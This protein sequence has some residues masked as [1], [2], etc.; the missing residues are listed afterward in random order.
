VVLHGRLFFDGFISGIHLSQSWKG[1]RFKRRPFFRLLSL[2]NQKLL[3][4]GML[5][6]EI[7]DKADSR[8]GFFFHRKSVLN[9]HFVRKVVEKQPVIQC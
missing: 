7:T 4:Q 6:L 3:L 1:E 2:N 5:D 9:L 8:Y